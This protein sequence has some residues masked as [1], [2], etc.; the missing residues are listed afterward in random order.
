ME[1][2]ELSVKLTEKD[3]SGRKQIWI[4][5]NGIKINLVLYKDITITLWRDSKKTDSAVLRE[6]IYN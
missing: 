6:Y 2:R 4:N 5:V 3:L 1:K